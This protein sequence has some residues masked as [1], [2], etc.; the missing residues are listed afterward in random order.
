M[1]N[2]QT[3]VSSLNKVM[4]QNRMALDLLTAKEGGVCMIIN[5]SCCAYI[6]KD[7]QIEADLNT[8][9]EKTQVFHEISLDDTSLGFRDLW[10]KLTSWLP[11]LGWLKQLFVGLITLMVLGI[12]VCIFLKCFLWCCWNSAEMYSDWKR[13]K[14]R[15]QV[16]TGKYFT[17]TLEKD[18]LL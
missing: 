7:N 6:N 17:R 16:E 15:H 1:K 12:F 14:V 18:E 4:L 3:E 5:T 10:D 9:W 13:N 2:L 11:N 8:L